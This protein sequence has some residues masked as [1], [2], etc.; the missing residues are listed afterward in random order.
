[1][2]ARKGFAP[3]TGASGLTLVEVLIALVVLTVGILALGRIFPAGSRSAVAARMQTAGNQY[4]NEVYE[5][6]RGVTKTSAALAVGRHPPS[7]F[8]SLG[9]TRAW[10]RF[11]VITQ[12]PAPLDSLLKVETTVIWG[13]A[14]PESVNII[15]YLLP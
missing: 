11:Y 2:T 7:G 6:L 9:T 5:D 13:S 10:R 12:M 4:A 3:V 15:G 8:D 1:M 14:K